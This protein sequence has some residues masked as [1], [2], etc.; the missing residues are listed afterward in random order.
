MRPRGW[1]A[2]KQELPIFFIKL[3]VSTSAASWTDSPVELVE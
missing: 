3:E 2:L 1:V